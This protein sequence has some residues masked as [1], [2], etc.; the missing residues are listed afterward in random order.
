MADR[1]FVAQRDSAPTGQRRFLLGAR[2]LWTTSLDVA[3]VFEK[4]HRNVLQ[5]IQA[6]ESVEEFNRLNFK[7]I[8]QG[9]RTAEIAGSPCTK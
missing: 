7:P 4:E 8:E 5:S 1:T 3:M 2:Q 9:Y 6:L